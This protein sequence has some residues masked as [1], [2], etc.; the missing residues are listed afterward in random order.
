MTI[1][2][3]I[4]NFIYT[5]PPLADGWIRVDYLGAAPGEYSIDAVPAAQVLT[6]Y[7]NGDSERQCEF[8]FT[9]CEAYGP[10][11]VQNLENNGFY[12]DFAAWLGE[13][14][15]KGNL[16][17]MSGGKTAER[18]EALSSGYLYRSG[19]DSAQYQIQCRLIYHQKGEI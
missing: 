1:L 17:A 4:R 8:V 6:Q 12:E 11:V 7:V 18:I 13:Q 14:T 16:P 19:T 2:E 3:S 15:R 9:S 5:Y 10:E